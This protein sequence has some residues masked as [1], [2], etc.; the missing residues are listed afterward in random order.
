MTHLLFVL[1][2]SFSLSFL[3]FC[4]RGTTAGEWAPTAA[5]IDTVSDLFD[6][7]NPTTRQLGERGEWAKYSTCDVATRIPLIV[8]PPPA[9]A[10]AVVGAG[11]SDA[12]FHYSDE[13]VE[14]VDLFPTLCSLANIDA[15]PLCSSDQEQQLC[16]EGSSFAHLLS[17]A[18][19]T[20]AWKQ[21]V[22][23]QYPRPADTPKG[24]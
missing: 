8:R 9:T 4:A 14:A 7:W 10:T 21:S 6:S 19:V 23:S 15:P 12:R 13:L 16:V 18:P 1:S 2:H 3:S 5:Q 17:G 20:S 22:F 24:P 11:Q